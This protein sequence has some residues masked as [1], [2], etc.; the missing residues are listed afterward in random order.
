MPYFVY[1]IRP[2]RRLEPVDSCDEYADAKRLVTRLRADLE[3]GDECTIRMVLAPD[4]ARAERLLSEVREP[5]PLGE[6][7]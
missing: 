1:K 3:S 4:T 7:A 6:D 5:R 2:P